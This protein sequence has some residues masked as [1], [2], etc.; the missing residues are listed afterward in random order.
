M[1]PLWSCLVPAIRRWGLV[2]KLSHPARGGGAGA[3]RHMTA[4]EPLALGLR[5]GTHLAGFWG[6][7]G[8]PKPN[9]TRCGM[10]VELVALV[11][12]E[13][14]PTCVECAR[15]PTVRVSSTTSSL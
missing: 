12:N 7:W 4:E 9:K 13:S 5:T 11:D 2:P 1:L 14:K 10:L 15:S 3:S 8:L 6:E